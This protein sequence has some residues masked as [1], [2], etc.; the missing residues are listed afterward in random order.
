MFITVSYLIYFDYKRRSSPEFR[1]QLRRQEKEYLKTQEAAQSAKLDS[2]KK[3]I[4][5]R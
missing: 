4:E 5:R 1:R 2:L 3:Q